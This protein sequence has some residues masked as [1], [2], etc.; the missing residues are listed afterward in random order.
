MAL[1][2]TNF[3]APLGRSSSH[4][5]ARMGEEKR[6]AIPCRREV[7]VPAWRPSQHRFYGGTLTSNIRREA[8]SSYWRQAVCSEGEVYSASTA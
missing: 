1:K 7:I 4:E 6:G 8:G 3:G 5:R 2:K